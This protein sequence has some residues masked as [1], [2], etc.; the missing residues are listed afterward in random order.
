MTKAP[1]TMYRFVNKIMTRV[2]T[3]EYL[4]SNSFYLEHKTYNILLYFLLQHIKNQIRVERKERFKKKDEQ[5]TF[6]IPITGDVLRLEKT[7]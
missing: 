5:Q 6:A 7:H 1:F 4:R 2:F 3:I